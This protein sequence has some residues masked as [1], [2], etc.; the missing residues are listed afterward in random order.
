[1]IKWYLLKGNLSW[2]LQEKFR[3]KWWSLRRANSEGGP[4]ENSL[5]KAL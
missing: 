3:V 5:V 4:G 1:M 2:M